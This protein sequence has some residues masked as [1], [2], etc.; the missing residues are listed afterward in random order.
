MKP[1]S[2]GVHFHK[3]VPQPPDRKSTQTQP[4]KRK[5]PPTQE[6][7]SSQRALHQTVPLKA[8]SS[9]PATASLA[10]A[11][12]PRR[13]TKVRTE[14]TTFAT[15]IDWSHA[16][17][18]PL[19]RTT[20]LSDLD[21]SFHMGLGKIPD[22]DFEMFRRK[23]IF[24]QQIDAG[25]WNKVFVLKCEDSDRTESSILFKQLPGEISQTLHDNF[26]WLG[27]V[28]HNPKFELRNIA[29]GKIADLLGFDVIMDCSAPLNTDGEYSGGL[30]MA[31][32]KG[33][34]AKD[35]VRKGKQML[36]SSP[37]FCRELTKLQLVDH[38]AGIPDRHRG[39]YFIDYQSGTKVKITGIDNDL[40]FCS[41]YMSPEP[42]DE[43]DNARV[44]M[45]GILDTGMAG[46][47]LSLSPEKLETALTGLASTEIDAAVS[48]LVKMQE[49]V[50]KLDALGR[51][52]DPAQ[53]KGPH[54]EQLKTYNSYFARDTAQE[55]DSD[56]D[57]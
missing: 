11:G 45:P 55:L 14:T 31:F 21:Q 4:G 41:E 15:P 57:Q 44:F 18:D 43:E 24:G 32:A 7:P 42:A 22:P 30:Y 49:H 47:I 51:V 25:S 23:G 9:L 2:Q 17:D 10:S 36:A 39:N 5:V 46:A 48:R 28:G 52:I 1:P 13:E 6:V 37:A 12:E 29:T 54:L 20:D 56:D 40:A 16:L 19:G 53:W 35:V 33:K 50:R 34:P 26:G 27:E 38:L 8:S 3:P